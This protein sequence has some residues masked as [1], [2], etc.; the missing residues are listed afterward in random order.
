M[1]TLRYLN[2]S[3][4]SLDIPIYP[5]YVDARILVANVHESHTVPAGAQFVVLIVEANIWIKFGGSAAIP[6]WDITDGSASI[7]VPAGASGYALEGATTI[8]LIAD[9]NTKVCLQFFS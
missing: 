8:G 1:R 3:G 5:D 6:P 7:L 2:R 4:V 9:S